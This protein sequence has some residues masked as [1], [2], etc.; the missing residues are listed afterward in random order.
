[1]KKLI[2]V[3]TVF[4][5]TW[6][7]N[8]KKHPF[9]Q[10]NKI[11]FGDTLR[12]SISKNDSYYFSKSIGLAYENELLTIESPTKKEIAFFNFMENTREKAFSKSLATKYELETYLISA[13]DKHSEKTP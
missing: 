9:S 10:K 11:L 13:P 6:L 5:N 7:V 8:Q 3:T 1:M 2:K 12:L 4:Q